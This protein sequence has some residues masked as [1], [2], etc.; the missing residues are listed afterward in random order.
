MARKIKYTIETFKKINQNLI[1][2][3]TLKDAAINAGID[4]D[5]ALIHAAK[6]LRLKRLYVEIDSSELDSFNIL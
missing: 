6:R 3:M 1:D 4:P 2:G 5:S